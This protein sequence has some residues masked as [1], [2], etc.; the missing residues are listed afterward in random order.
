MSRADAASLASLGIRLIIDLRAPSDSLK[1]RPKNSPIPIANIPLHDPALK[2]HGRF[3]IFGYLFARDGGDRFR[4]FIGDYYRHIAFDRTATV[5]EV[6]SL[7]AGDG[8]LPALVHC[9][10]GKDR[11]GWIAALLQLFAGVPYDV[12]RADYVATDTHYAPR[13][14]LL[15]RIARIVTLGR[16]SAERLRLMTGAH[17]ELLDELYQTIIDRHGSVEAYLREACTIDQVTLD[18]LKARLIA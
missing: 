4:R 9:T 3:A 15:I 13:V 16:V 8:S 7:L 11:T 17:P 10:A 2:R 18:R 14:A 1:R 5:R 12:V 6:I